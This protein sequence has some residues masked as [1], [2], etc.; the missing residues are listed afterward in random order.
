MVEHRKG[1]NRLLFWLYSGH[2]RTPS[3]FRWSMLVF[4]IVTIGIFIFHP[5]VSWHDGVE[6]ATGVWLWIDIFIAAVITLDFLAR[7]YIERHK[8]RFFTRW[9]N[10][11]DLV[12]VATLILPIFLQNLVFLR[13]LRVVRL[14]RA[15]EYL[16]REHGVSTWL[17]RNGF[18]IAKVVNLFVFIFLVTALVFVTQVDHNP[19]IKN[20][21]DALYFTVGTL[22]TVGL[23]DITLPDTF[24]RWI[25]IAIMVLGV[26]L[27]LQL[28][29]AIALG[30]KIKRNCPACR[31][32][33][34]ERDAAHCRRCGANLFP[35]GEHEVAVRD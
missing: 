12:V 10:I 22:T 1:L 25:T 11:A 20:Y 17:H 14:L 21:L 29:R 19:D 33:L 6:A 16:H 4:D 27:F 32:A 13:V 18:V 31:L 26:T 24:G 30:D 7:F 9:S 2:G 5:L 35:E 8:W 28:I 3:I 34:H 23:G 15:F